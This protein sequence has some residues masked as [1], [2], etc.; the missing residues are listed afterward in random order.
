MERKDYQKKI[1]LLGD[2]AVGK[3]SLIK[4]FVLDVFDDKYIVTVGT[5]VTRKELDLTDTDRGLKICL[6][7]MIWDILGQEEYKSL[8]TM[9]FRNAN[10]AL[11]VCDVTRKKT[12]QNMADWATSLFNCVGEIPIVFLANKTDLM[13]QAEVT[14]VDITEVAT[15]FKASYLL[16]SAKTGFNVNLAFKMLGEMLVNIR[17][18]NPGA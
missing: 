13:N 5:K 2:A 11:I 16:T 4:K 18:N 15:R 3:T 10:G 8:R 17:S 12:L 7:M 14:E 6:T 1:C 9:Y